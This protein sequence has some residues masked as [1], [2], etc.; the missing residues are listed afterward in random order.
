MNAIK[1]LQRAEDVRDLESMGFRIRAIEGA[2]T[3]PRRTG[4]EPHQGEFQAVGGY[5]CPE[6]GVEMPGTGFP[7]PADMKE[8]VRI[9][10]FLLV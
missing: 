2:A 6:I 10:H 7:Q 3:V 9:H 1:R 8:S 5:G 4:R